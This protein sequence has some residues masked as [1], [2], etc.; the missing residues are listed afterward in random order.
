MYVYLKKCFE[1]IIGL[2]EGR[3]SKCS[4]FEK[5][6]TPFTLSTMSFFK[7][8]LNPAKTQG[9]V[10]D[11]SLLYTSYANKNIESKEKVILY[12][13]TIPLQLRTDAFRGLK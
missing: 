1:N 7:S 3:V 4:F 9:I 5:C 13:T 8:R 12:V 6:N 10:S 2:W 11:Y